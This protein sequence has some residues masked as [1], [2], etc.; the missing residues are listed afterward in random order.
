MINGAGRPPDWIL[1]Q[2][3]IWRRRA[4][5]S[6]RPAARRRPS[7]SARARLLSTWRRPLPARPP[8]TMARAPQSDRAPD[9][10]RKPKCPI[11]TSTWLPAAAPAS[12][13]GARVLISGARGRVIRFRPGRQRHSLASGRRRAQLAGGPAAR[14]RRINHLGG[15]AR[16]GEHQ[17]KTQQRQQTCATLA[18]IKSRPTGATRAHPSRPSR[19]AS[20][21]SNAIYFGQIQFYSRARH[22]TPL[23]SWRATT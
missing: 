10:G 4:Q 12:G 19:R 22:D 2:N 11:W 7:I 18:R 8:A 14:W 5:L 13:G 17:I 9:L 16:L 21:Q 15:R 6:W 3:S 20:Q 1:R 23:A